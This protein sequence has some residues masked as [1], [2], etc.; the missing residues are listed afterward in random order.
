MR[1]FAASLATETNTFAPLPTGLKAFE[2]TCLY[3]A[4]THP[5]R[6]TL[7]SAPLWV[8]REQAAERGWTLAEG[9]VAFAMPG[10][11]TTRAAWDTLRDQL[12][13]DLRAAMPVDIVLLGLHGAM[14]ADGCDDCEGELLRQVRAIVGSDAVVG[15]ELD[16]HHH[17]T[18][19]MLEHADLLVSFKHYPHTDS[20]ERARE[21]VALCDAAARRRMHPTVGVADCGMIT[22]LHTTRS[23]AREFVA[24]IQAMEGRDGVL[25]I[26]V[27]HGFP[28][29]DVPDMGTKVFVYTD[30]NPAQAA[31]LARQLAGELVAMRD[32]LQP[33]ELAPDAAIDAALALQAT[34]PAEGERAGPVVIADGAD[35]PGGGAPGDSTWILRRLVERRVAGAAVGPLWDPMAVRTAFAAGVGARLPMRLGGKVCALSGQP[36]DADCRVLAL[37]ND[38]RMSVFGNAQASLGQAAL[39]EA[40]GVLVSLTSV[41]NQAMGVEVFTG[42]GLDL[43]GLQLVVVKSSQHFHAAYAPIA[44]K[45]LYSA[46]PGVVSADLRALP[47]RKA[48]RALW[49]LAAG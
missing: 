28:W 17:L 4:G 18:Q 16:P 42:F 49:P 37:V 46:A 32:A 31:E 24:R 15:A 36:L 40:D 10:G 35:N 12:L 3:P 20:V 44:R 22:V 34:T 47:Y 23:P 26:S 48:S 1:V 13:D 27:T 19:A 6:P 7:F 21:L 11:I 14:V 5:D 8:A 2:E 45:V 29:G 39:V 33:G 43:A 9:L 38:L 30:G 41:R 25:S